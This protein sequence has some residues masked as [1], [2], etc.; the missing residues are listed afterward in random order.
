MRPTSKWRLYRYVHR[1]GSEPF[2]DW[3]NGLDTGVQRRIRVAL[4]RLE[5]GNMSSVKWIAGNVGEFRIHAGAGYRIY[6]ARHGSDSL[7]LLAGG[8]KGSQARDIELAR[9]FASALRK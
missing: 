7:V 1:D 5:A 9:I 4:A 2:T 3:L 8:D 6:F